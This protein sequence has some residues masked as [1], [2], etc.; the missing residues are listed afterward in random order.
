[1][2]G[3]TE[4]GEEGGL[5]NPL[6]PIATETAEELVLNLKEKLSRADIRYFVEQMKRR[7]QER[8][9]WDEYIRQKY[10]EKAPEKRDMFDL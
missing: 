5:I 1:M 2:W 4:S 9:W 10:T 6:E 7:V 3:T 8:E